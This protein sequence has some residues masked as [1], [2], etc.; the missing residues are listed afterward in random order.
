MKRILDNLWVQLLLG[1]IAAILGVM[2]AF[3]LAILSY[4]QYTGFEL[5]FGLGH[6]GDQSPVTFGIA[7]ILFLLT[8]T[9]PIFVWLFLNKHGKLKSAH[10]Y[11][12]IPSFILFL[13]LPLWL[14]M[15]WQASSK[16]QTAYKDYHAVGGRCTIRDGINRETI[17]DRTY[18]VECKNGVV[19]GFTRVYNAQGVLVFEGTNI[20]GKLNGTGTSYDDNGKVSRVT[21]YKEGEPEGTEVFYDP[22]GSTKL[23]VIHEQGRAQQIYFQMPEQFYNVYDDL[24]LES[25]RIICKNQGTNLVQQYSFSCQNGL[26]NG[27]FIRKGHVSFRVTMTNGIAD[28]IYEQFMDGKLKSHLEFKNG[29]LDGKVQQFFSDGKL[30]YEGQYQGGL[31]QGIF[32]RYDY[33]GNLE[34]EVVFKDGKLIKINKYAPVPRP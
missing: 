2:V 28:G 17:G 24:D 8:F 33:E 9:F 26:I 27:E 13:T 4:I 12:R 29:A 31:Q 7:A 11:V 15:G 10:S 6:S 20:N 22:N 30:E 3:P 19:N 16:V 1:L 34:S 5:F 23:Y 18:E 25:Q 21:A 14:Y 32:R